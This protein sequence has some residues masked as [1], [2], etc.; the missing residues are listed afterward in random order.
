MRKKPGAT[1]GIPS[2]AFTLS[3]G[4]RH[5]TNHLS[6]K[7]YKHRPL[8]SGR[9]EP[10]IAG[11]SC[12]QSLSREQQSSALHSQ[13]RSHMLALPYLPI[14]VPRCLSL[15]KREEQAR[16]DQ[17]SP[18]LWLGGGRSSLC[19]QAREAACIKLYAASM[20]VLQAKSTPNS[21][22]CKATQIPFNP[23]QHWRGSDIL[24][25]LRRHYS[26]QDR[27]PSREGEK[28]KNK[29]AVVQYLQQLLAGPQEQF[30]GG[31]NQGGH[32]AVKQ[33]SSEII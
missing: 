30:G 5:V 16:E 18:L 23:S 27:H 22:W 31:L 1:E 10:V 24:H 28:K 19:V 21:F 25:R 2:Q 9:E 11:E 26:H 32:T 8:R 29:Q 12:H 17:P 4:C 14:T 6:S 20:L 13:P 15:Q 3:L 33:A 7:D